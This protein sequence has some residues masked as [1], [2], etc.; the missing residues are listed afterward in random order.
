MKNAVPA[1]AA[2][3]A[4]SR[5]TASQVLLRIP[6]ALSSSFSQQRVAVVRALI[7]LPKLILADEPTGSLD[8]VSAGNLGK[9]LI[10]LNKEEGVTLIVVTHSIEL[11]RLMDKVYRIDNG[12]LKDDKVI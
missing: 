12:N 4:A 9:L 10:D 1:Q 2:L 6:I 11:A 3:A 8:Q 7:N 5:P